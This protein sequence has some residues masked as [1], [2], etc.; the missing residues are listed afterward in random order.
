MRGGFILRRQKAFF[1]H[2]RES[3]QRDEKNHCRQTDTQQYIELHIAQ[4][5][6]LDDGYV[7]YNGVGLGAV[8]IITGD[9]ALQILSMG[10][11]RL[12]NGI[13]FFI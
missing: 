5:F 9:A 6:P 7:T 11:R 4:S 3:G 12:E 1:G 10:N 8:K 13:I 2:P